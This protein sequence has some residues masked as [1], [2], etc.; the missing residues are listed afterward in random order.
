MYYMGLGTMD[1]MVHNLTLSYTSRGIAEPGARNLAEEEVV[2]FEWTDGQPIHIERIA[3]IGHRLKKS[4]ENTGGKILWKK[5]HGGAYYFEVGKYMLTCGSHILHVAD[6]E[7]ECLDALNEHSGHIERFK[8]MVSAMGWNEMEAW[9]EGE[10]GYPLPAREC[11][12]ERVSTVRTAASARGWEATIRT[13][14]HPSRPIKLARIYS[15]EHGYTY[16]PHTKT[17]AAA[18]TSAYGVAVARWLPAREL[19]KAA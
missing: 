4:Y 8:S 3:P 14:D 17:E 6:T 7:Q 18:I 15:D 10:H 5:E 19:Q 2:E 1:Q 11:G 12:E 16:G 13:I 9:F